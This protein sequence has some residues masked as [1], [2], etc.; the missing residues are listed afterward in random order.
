MTLQVDGLALVLLTR[1]VLV[2]VPFFVVLAR[3]RSE[4]GGA[5]VLELALLPL[6]ALIAWW[7]QRT[8]LEAEM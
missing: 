4:L 3:A 6:P 8:T 1:V 2:N 5:L 7:C